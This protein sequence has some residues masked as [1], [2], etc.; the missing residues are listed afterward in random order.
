MA[1]AILLSTVFYFLRHFVVTI[2]VCLNSHNFHNVTLWCVDSAAA[3]KCGPNGYRLGSLLVEHLP[4]DNVVY[5]GRG[6][7]YVNVQGSVQCQG[8]YP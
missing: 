4:V 7:K 8:V 6:A 5:T 2:Y 1:L 3:L